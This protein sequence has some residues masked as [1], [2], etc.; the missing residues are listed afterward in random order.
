MSLQIN[1]DSFAGIANTLGDLPEALGSAI[2]Q[3][4]RQA[5]LAQDG[6][7]DSS[8][9]PE[10]QATA[11]FQKEFGDLAQDKEAFHALMKQV[12]GENYD[13]GKA[14][15]YRQMALKGDYSFLPPVRFV[16]REELA[17][18][19]GAYNSEDGVIYLA[20]DL[21]GNPALMQ[22]TFVE[23]AGHHLDAMLNT[24]DSAGDEGELFRRLMSGEK[25]TDGQI[26]EIRAEND[27]GTIIVDGKKVEVEF[28]GF[29]D[30][31]D[32][33]GDAA[34]AV[35]DAVSGAVNAVGDAVSEVVDGVGDA[36]GM[37]ADGIMSG[38]G[39]FVTNALQGNFGD[40]FQSLL[41]G[42]DKAFLQAPKRLVNA[43]INSTERLIQAPT[44]L[45]PEPVGGAI[46][47]FEARQVD[48][49][50]SVANAG[51][52]IARNSIRTAVQIPLDLATDLYD[53]GSK[54]VK[55]DFT[56]ALEGLGWAVAHPFVST[57]NLVV[58]DVMIG[59]QAVVNV[60]GNELYLHEPSR[61]LTDTEKDRLREMY[62]DSID[63]DSIRLHVDN[64]STKLGMAAHA[65]GNDIYIPKTNDAGVANVNPDGTLTE[66]GLNL[67]VHESGH[68]WQNQNGGIDYV[69][70]A[71]WSNFAAWASGG[72]RN[73]AYEWRE[74]AD[75]NKPFGNL[76]PEQQAE[77]MQDIDKARQ[78][79]KTDGDTTFDKNDFSPALTDEQFA[80]AMA[81]W[82]QVQAG[83]G[84]P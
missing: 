68:V 24:S 30:L 13:A 57:A 48:S 72:D 33:V 83:T 19:N 6:A 70:K 56:G 53:A 74:G 66:T 54:L 37:F 35:G 40:A 80:Y 78:H 12:Y 50:R 23:E 51:M 1:R 79:D 71:L 8:S 31:V 69:G 27:H 61:P 15:Q 17:G 77:L 7:I 25:L 84:A 4:L 52:D 58:D 60:V 28:W 38:L 81:A 63:V 3:A 82:A 2:N 10:S 43:A 67:L 44:Y 46:R 22:Q 64:I 16:S 47:D 34:S 11:A 41:D 5:G 14:E 65:V 45:I 42:A 32:A 62:G 76:N 73:A 75:A 20:E 55:G 29:G 39:G 9:T 59:A 21:K 49:V 18:G 26:A 36:I